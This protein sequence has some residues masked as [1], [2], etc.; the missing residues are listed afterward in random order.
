MV[1]KRRI[2]EQWTAEAVAR[3]REEEAV[4]RVQGMVLRSDRLS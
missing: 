3:A 1:A 4:A 2:E